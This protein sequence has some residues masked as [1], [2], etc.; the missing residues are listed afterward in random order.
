MLLNHL[1]D[2]ITILPVVMIHLL[3][4]CCEGVSN[5]QYFICLED[6]CLLRTNIFLMSCFEVPGVTWV[7]GVITNMK[8]VYC[9]FRR[10]PR[11]V[12]VLWH[13]TRKSLHYTTHMKLYYIFITITSVKI[14]KQA[15]LDHNLIKW[16]K[17][18]YSQSQK[19]LQTHIYYQS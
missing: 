2:N 7:L 13:S 16:Y 11:R 9:V 4:L 19:R 1:L 12:G 10:P 14:Y 5:P 17:K 15:V 8:P 3:L 6:Q 18:Y